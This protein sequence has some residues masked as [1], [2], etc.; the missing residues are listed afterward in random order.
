[1]ITAVSCLTLPRAQLL[2]ACDF[3]ASA[4]SPEGDAWLCWE[5][6]YGAVTAPRMFLLWRSPDFQ[7]RRNRK[8]GHFE[9]SLALSQQTNGQVGIVGIEFDW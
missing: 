1:M 2:S 7:S 9:S 5:D 6:V 3:K 8:L 4:S